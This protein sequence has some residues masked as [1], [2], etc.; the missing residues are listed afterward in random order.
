M[1]NVLPMISSSPLWMLVIPSSIIHL[2]STVSAS[3]IPPQ[4]DFRSV[5][6]VSILKLC[7]RH[8]EKA[9]CKAQEICS[10]FGVSKCQLR[11]ITKFKSPS[12]HQAAQD[13]WFYQYLSWNSITDRMESP[14]LFSCCF[15]RSCFIPLN[16]LVSLFI[17]FLSLPK[18][19]SCE[20][21]KLL[22]NNFSHQFHVFSG[23]ISWVLHQW[24]LASPNSYRS[25]KDLFEDCI[26]SITLFQS[27]QRQCC[28]IDPPHA[29]W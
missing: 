10:G 18:D 17:L 2:V 3:C 15:H 14:T 28:I 23:A 4:H 24:C 13:S 5:C 9:V 26:P 29:T 12:S 1:V 19:L 8:V 20:L 25:G 7:L 6:K 22:R 27:R 11:K 16:S 21:Y